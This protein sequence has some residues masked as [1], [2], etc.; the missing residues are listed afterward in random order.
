MQYG[1][2]AREPREKTP[3]T[4]LIHRCEVFLAAFRETLELLMTSISAASASTYQSPLQRLQ[5]EL[6]SEVTSGAISSA[7]QDALSSALS[8]IDSSAGKP[9]ERPGERYKAL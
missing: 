3:L 1:V 9:R 4:S 8:D 7:D 5:D 2:T 6:Q